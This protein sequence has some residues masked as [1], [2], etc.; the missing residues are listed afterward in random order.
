MGEQFN[1][2][3][4]EWAA[5]YDDTV[6][7]ANVEYQ[8]VFRNYD[9]ILQEISAR[10]HGFVIEFGVGTGNLTKKL[11]ENGLEVIGIEPSDNMRKIAQEKLPN[12]KIMKGN[13]LSFPIQDKKADTIVS[14]YAFHHLTDKEKEQAIKLYTNTLKP[15]GK[16]IFGDT[17]F[18]NN[19][20]KEEAYLQ[21]KAKGYHR[22]AE[23][24]NT[25]YYTTIPKMEQ[26]L[27][28][29]EF[30]S[31]F[32]QRNDYVWIMEAQFKGKASWESPYNA[33]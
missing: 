7:G 19:K 11:M 6:Q 27:H 20:Q 23:D 29:Y 30:T 5:S 8:E 28:T 17:M 12:S 2:L 31:S 10:S 18:E 14:S 16:I 15:H 26:I 22:L 1:R 13:F 9:T 4:D 21:A 33:G 24:L 25:E 3:F 32:K